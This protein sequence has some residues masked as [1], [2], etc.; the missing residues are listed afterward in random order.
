MC[1]H[2][3]NS[4]AKDPPRLLLPCSTVRKDPPL[5]L[6]VLPDFDP[7]F[8]QGTERVVESVVVTWPGGQQRVL[9]GLELDKLHQV[10]L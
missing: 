5:L 4:R 6:T 10:K 9:R 7:P 1:S 2:G 3:L 8:E